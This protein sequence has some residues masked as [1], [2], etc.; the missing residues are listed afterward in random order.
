MEV[1]LS[2]ETERLF[3]RPSS[4]ED[5]PFFLELMNMPK[6]IQ[7]IGDR[8]VRDL[9]AAE[10]YIRERHLP[11]LEKLGYGNYVVIR[12][13]DGV[14][15]GSCG[16]YGRE[17]LDHVDIGFAFLPAFEGYGYAYESA[18]RIRDAAFQEF[19]LSRICAI[20]IPENTASQRLL[21]KL[22]FTFEKTTRI[23]NDPVELLLYGLNQ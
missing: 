7:N 18:V 17:G 8:N 9:A 15:L 21:E 13:S 10:Q 11:Q 22:G 5:A 23:P 3:L 1:Y 6:W 2:F 4:V 20:T 19:G 16:L 14:K 12:K